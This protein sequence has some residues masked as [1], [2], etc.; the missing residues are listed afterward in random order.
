MQPSGTSSPRA[1]ASRTLPRATRLVAKSR[2]TAIAAARPRHADAERVRHEPPVAAAERRD[3]RRV[4]H[5]VDEVDRDEAG[6]RRL[7]GV[8][9]DPADVEGAAERHRGEPER[10]RARHARRDPLS[11][12]EL[13]EAAPPVH[14]EDG[15][16]A[17]LDRGV[18][19]G[20]EEAAPRWRGRTAGASRCRGCRGRRG[21]RPRGGAATTPASGPAA[22]AAMRTREARSRSLAAETT[23]G[24]AVMARRVYRG[25]RARADRRRSG[26]D[27]AGRGTRRSSRGG[28]GRSRSGPGRAGR[29]AGGR[30]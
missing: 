5:H 18:G 1:R 8:R 16:A 25:R 3:E 24:V 9:A 2:S 20:I 17:V 21:S 19:A 15:A 11:P 27:R 30:R 4:A 13:A 28:R 22:P 29:R 23:V 10:P 12:D 26:G 6:C 7:L 14:R